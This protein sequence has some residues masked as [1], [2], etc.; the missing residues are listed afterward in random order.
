MRRFVLLG[1][2]LCLGAPPLLRAQVDPL[3]SE[4][5]RIIQQREDLKN[6]IRYAFFAQQYERA[7]QLCDQLENIDPQGG[8]AQQYR[9]M[10][11]DALRTMP[12][13]S[14]DIVVTPGASG[15]AANAATASP[16]APVQIPD[17]GTAR[18]PLPDTS[19]SMPAPAPPPMAA[20]PAASP[21]PAPAAEP[22]VASVPPSSP[23]YTPAPRNQIQLP[24][25]GGVDRLVAL[26]GLVVVVFILAAALL[27]WKL[28]RRVSRVTSTLVRQ[29]QGASEDEPVIWD[30]SLVEAPPAESEP[31]YGALD[32]AFSE[33]QAYTP[34]AVV[35]APPPKSAA[36]LA[37]PW[38]SLDE[39]V[40][41]IRQE[42]QTPYRET[43]PPPP[44][45]P[46]VVPVSLD[47]VGIESLA[48]VP[49]VVSALPPPKRNPESTQ[50]LKLDFG[51][52]TASASDEKPL[53]TLDADDVFFLGAT[54]K[55]AEPPAAPP[56]PP[57]KKSPATTDSGRLDLSFHEVEP[58]PPKAPA[59]E[60]APP[61][62]TAELFASPKIFEEKTEE[63]TNVPLSLDDLFGGEVKKPVSSSANEATQRLS[64]VNET[65]QRLTYGAD[66]LAFGTTETLPR[67]PAEPKP[68][69]PEETLTLPSTPPRPAGEE[70]T[71]HL[72]RGEIKDVLRA[73][74][75][76]TE[77]MAPEEPPR[78][79][80]EVESEGKGTNDALFMDYYR[81]GL[82]A[83]SQENW[84]QAMHAFQLALN[85]RPTS[86]EVLRQLRAA[87][88][89]QRRQQASGSSAGHT[90]GL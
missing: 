77:N 66:D 18:V 64:A 26:L 65:T 54:S 11:R 15:E 32:S 90:P 14:R 63:I 4:R 87:E 13:G 27:L 52:A 67:K 68:F 83:V 34:P 16:N 2:L 8:W 76:P 71:V 33:A 84:A 89:A 20:P 78:T 59:Q 47:E 70:Q 37:A 69:D 46:E 6:Q 42:L 60:E 80:E 88:S 12:P 53:Q 61:M 30:A 9:V 10:A 1:I 28:S 23:P 5:G 79:G 48:M 19:V 38:R 29:A 51:Q 57:A 35:S 85:I 39:A 41:A 73:V 49:P 21:S 22:S 82:A 86:A 81:Q 74:P 40:D 44:K 45:P 7:L 36:T 75:P 3:D 25:I 43:L 62:T 72:S 50:P 56:P 24:L 31:E 55:P 17:V 58:E